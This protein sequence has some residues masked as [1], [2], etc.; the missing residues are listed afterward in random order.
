MATL[1]ADGSYYVHIGDTAR[2]GGEEYGYRLRI[3][4][5]QP[6]F[7]LRVVPS[8]L[9][10]RAKSSATLTIYA[11]RKD[12]FTGPI[13]LILKDPSAGFSIAPIT[14]SSTQTVAR[15]NLKTDLLVTKEPASLS[16]LGSAK[17]GGRELAHA[18]VPAEDRMQ[19][20]L[21]RHLVP[22]KDLRVLVFDPAYEPPP[23]R[24]AWACPPP[25]IVTNTLVSATA[26]NATNIIARTNSAADTNT[27]AAADK[28]K[29][30]RQQVAVRL[31]QLKLLF[32]EEML[33]DEFYGE[34]VAECAAAE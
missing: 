10:V 1:P 3:S 6:D 21:W 4:A 33:T 8:S 32:E 7:D 26:S 25:A 13:K 20:F 28:P 23:K 22:A 12:G 34:K 15:F 18:A 31:K 29:F 17:V 2:Q 14:L 30:T 11:Q 27:V 9:T 19:A 24:I 16:I 5:P